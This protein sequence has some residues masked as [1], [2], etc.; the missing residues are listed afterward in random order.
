M[1]MPGP[2]TRVVELRI[3]GLG[4]ADPAAAVGALAAV[5]V[6]GDGTSRLV[7][8]ADRLMR[9]APGPVLLADGH[10][11]PRTVE[12][13]LWDGLR[14]GRAQALLWALLLP[15]ALANTAYWTLPC[16]GAHQRLG[17]VVRAAVRVCALLLTALLAAQF[18]VLAVDAVGGVA[19]YL[20]VAPA[21]AVLHR[22]GGGTRR[23]G[24]AGDAATGD[25][26]GAEPS[27]P[28]LRGAHTTAVLAAP[29]WL[30]AG[31]AAG[32]SAG[33][34]WWWAL[35][36]A[37]LALCVLAAARETPSTADRPWAWRP[38][39]GSAALILAGAVWQAAPTGGHTGSGLT[40]AALGTALAAG[41]LVLAAPLGLLVRR[42]RP[43]RQRLSDT[44]QPWLAGWLALPVL[45]L[46]GFLGAG[47]AAAATLAVHGASGGTVPAGYPSLVAAWGIAGG[48]LAVA[49][50][51]AAV[52]ARTGRPA[53]PLPELD[54]LHPRADAALRRAWRTAA[55]V[56]R[57]LPHAV[58]LTSATLMAGATMTGLA[59]PSW[60]VA[61]G[62]GVLA[63]VA[64]GAAGV[65][66]TVDR[67]PGV[68]R[69]LALLHGLGTGWPRLAHPL[70]PPSPATKAL[71]ELL[72]RARHHLADP[73]TR[74][75][76]VGE[77]Y[78][79]V[80]A[81]LAVR[82]LLS[83]LD[84]AQAERV[85]LVTV[86][87]P[88]QW[89]Y[90]RGFPSAVPPE[91]LSELAA[92]LG[93]RWR[94]LCRGTDTGGGAVTTWSRSRYGED[95][96][97]LGL[98]PDGSVGPLDAAIAGRHGGWVLGADHWLTD[99]LPTPP[100]GRRWHPGLLRDADYAA[101]PE[102]DAAVAVAAGLAPACAPRA[103]AV[104]RGSAAA[105]AGRAAPASRPS[106]QHEG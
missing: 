89:A 101:D 79:A 76:L 44:W 45:V 82:G 10:P 23:A 48:V 66:W 9:P 71:P 36:L 33:A 100:A 60:L 94:A 86:G 19:G 95:L 65:C 2:D 62:T 14:P 32:P 24:T 53:I 3:P 61:L 72:E 97:G 91:S 49:A 16:A 22:L 96:L 35:A 56:R 8:P 6:A 67:R 27:G 17:G 21:A 74:L 29:A 99:P 7:R 83:G 11:V 13:Y 55:L 88:L 58:L 73:G 59:P 90:Q 1:L 18:A 64:L 68:P 78:G 85:G 77:G 57:H 93:G 52:L 70:G 50:A 87:A 98:R 42:T 63:A 43:C 102:W 20:P 80:L 37:E 31:G 84:P 54:A 39:I 25:G 75:V 106:A 46:A 51:S 4:R 30:A 38:V 105:W 28:A 34:G 81:T 47:S 41:W 12:G 69:R 26:F 104:P 103:E 15:C 5:D 92:A 40:V